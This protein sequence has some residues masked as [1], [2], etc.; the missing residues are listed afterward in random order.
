M[1]SRHSFRI[2]TSIGRVPLNAIVAQTANV[3][4]MIALK[5]VTSTSD[6]TSTLV[7]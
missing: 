5:N 1:N 4:N 7:S 6:N 3:H 2:S